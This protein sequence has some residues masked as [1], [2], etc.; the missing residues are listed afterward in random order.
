MIVHINICDSFIFCCLL[1]TYYHVKNKN[2]N[3]FNEIEIFLHCDIDQYFFVY[4]IKLSIR[5]RIYQR[6]F[7]SI[8]NKVPFLKEIQVAFYNAI[9]MLLFINLLTIV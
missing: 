6:K 9:N 2:L 3:Q 8:K 4:F 7:T 5:I 1:D